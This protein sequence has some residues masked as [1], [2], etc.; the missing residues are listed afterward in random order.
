M[1]L[2][3]ARSVV[4]NKTIPLINNRL[5]IIETYSY[6]F[7]LT[8]DN[9][10]QEGTLVIDDVFDENNNIRTIAL[11]KEEK[12]PLINCLGI[13]SCS[14]NDIAIIELDVIT[15][16][17]N[18][19]NASL[20]FEYVYDKGQLLF[21]KYLNK[22]RN[23]DSSRS[24]DHSLSL[25]NYMVV[26]RELLITLQYFYPKIKDRI[27]YKLSSDIVKIEYNEKD[28]TNKSIEWILCNLDEI[29]YDRDLKNYPGSFLIENTY[30]IPRRIEVE[31]RI[32]NIN[33]YENQIILGVVKSLGSK[34]QKIMT[35]AT[36]TLDDYN[37]ISTDYASFDSLKRT[38]ISSEL[39]RL[40][41][42]R[43][44]YSSVKRTYYKLFSDVRPIEEK[45]KLTHNFK[46][47]RHYQE[48]F[49]KIHLFY[50]SSL[51]ISGMQVVLGIKNIDQLYEY[52]NLYRIVEIFE[53]YFGNPVVI[54]STDDSI[55]YIVFEV[56]SVTYRIYFQLIIKKKSLSPQYPWL[57]LFINSTVN[58]HY[59]P[60]IVIEKEEN[61]NCCYAIFDAKYSTKKWVG[62]NANTIGATAQKI[63]GKYYFSISYRDEQYKKTD[64]LFLLYPSNNNTNI[65]TSENNYYPVI[66]AIPSIPSNELALDNTIR[67]IINDWK[68][69]S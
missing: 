53:K 48:V 46:K 36:K 14:F 29:I 41:K 61:G 23:F 17:M 60:D 69:P 22:Q 26:L 28:I 63:I 40:E 54:T 67:H 31:K 16:K 9:V 2:L 47:E 6:C 56:G 51:S 45:P 43:S 66:G 8:I 32:K 21:D 55:D 37:Y 18:G 30:A 65:F 62:S 49:K 13:F 57:K 4:D 59:T 1:Y 15:L 19:Q 24:I 39:E 7:S 25:L 68:N 34:L 44:I 12:H 10:L 11:N 3:K 38:I 58:S 27:L 52:Y 20:L 5:Q 35:M 42:M 33:I 50:N 64:Y